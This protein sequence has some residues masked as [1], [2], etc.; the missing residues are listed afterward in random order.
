MFY[1]DRYARK[2]TLTCGPSMTEQ[3]HKDEVDIHRIMKQYQATG[4]V[5]HVNKHK[6]SYGD[7]TGH[8]EYQEAQNIIAN[9][10]SLF[11]S[12][13]SHIRVDF[14][15]DPG[16]FIA[17]MSDPD[18]IEQIDAYGLDSSHLQKQEKPAP[19]P[20]KQPT[21]PTEPST[22]SEPPSD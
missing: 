21:A 13:P 17:F 4:V 22:A 3:A 14:N 5:T 19:K 9:A 11:E 8:P 18:N 2:E 10:K 15:N 16:A 1:Y 12:V 7:Y 6:G 20:S